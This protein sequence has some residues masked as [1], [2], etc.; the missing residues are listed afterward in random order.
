MWGAIIGAGVSLASNA[1]GSW[2][3][4]KRKK[5]AEEK[6][7]AEIDKL[8]GELDNEIGTNYLD[9]ADARAAIRRATDANTEALRQLNTQAIRGGATDE[10][11][12]AMASKLNKSTADLVGHLAGVG[13]QHKDR[14]KAARRSLLLN[15]AAH[16]YQVG[17]D[18]SG[19]DNVLSSIG[20]AAQNLGNA[21]TKGDTTTTT[22]TAQTSGVPT[23]DERVDIASGV[24]KDIMAKNPM[25]Q[26]I[27]DPQQFAIDEA[28]GRNQIHYGQ[29]L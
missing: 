5:E 26:Q 21:W 24:A 2:I 6:Y 9:R 7:S 23:V 17:S 10:A 27:I 28:L 29:T 16:D 8:K 4:N 20:T 11:K 13:E 19:I 14:M 3:A 12:V 15:K 22:P 18:V 25:I 1:L